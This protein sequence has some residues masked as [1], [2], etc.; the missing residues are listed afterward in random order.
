MKIFQEWRVA[1][2]EACPNDFCPDDILLSS[3]KDLCDWLCKFV[4]ETRRSDGTEYTPRSLYLILC[5]FQRHIRSIKSEEINFFQDIPFKPLR[6]VCDSVFKRLHSKGIGAELK[7]TPINEED[8]LGE[9]KV[10]DLDTP[11]GLLCAVFFYNGKH[12]CLRGGQEQ[13]KLKLSQFVRETIM[14]DGKCLGCYTYTEFGSKNHQ[15]GY[16]SFNVKNKVVKQ[17]ENS[18][19]LQRCYVKILDK[20]FELLPKEAKSNDVFYLSPLPKKP[21]QSGKA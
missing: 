21:T 12:F 15:G 11:I 16:T 2:N 4:S 14:V 18:M 1:R 6:N 9:K 3:K 8:R 5:G 13:R 10:L 19:N 20:Y 7:A 17:Y